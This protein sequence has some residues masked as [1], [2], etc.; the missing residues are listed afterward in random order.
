MRGSR[1]QSLQNADRDEAYIE[2]YLRAAR[3]RAKDSFE[4]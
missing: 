1:Y 2:R 3:S 4:A